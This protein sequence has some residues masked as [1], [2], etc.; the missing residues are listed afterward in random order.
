MAILGIMMIV[1]GLILLAGARG[2]YRG[3][4]KTAKSYEDKPGDN[5]EFLKLLRGGMVVLRIIG[6]LLVL[7]GALFLFI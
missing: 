7:V 3:G 1:V 5:E 4:Q 2:V 6:A